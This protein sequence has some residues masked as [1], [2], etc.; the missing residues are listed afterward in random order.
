MNLEEVKALATGII[1]NGY[2][3]EMSEDDIKMEMF[4]QKV[5]Y[6]KLNTLFKTISISLGLMV[7]P[8]EVTDGIN[9]LVEKIDWESKTEWSQVAETL[10]H[11]V[12]NVDGSTVARALT[13]VR[14]HCRDEEIEL[15]KKPRASG[16]GGGAKGGKVAAAIADI[17]AKGVPTKEELYNAVLPLVKGPKNA[18]AFVNMYFGICVAVKT[19]ESL[20]TA[21][22]STKDQKMP[23][24]ETAEVESDEDED[25]MDD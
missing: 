16:G 5:P 1:E 20:A 24:Y 23:E 11:I 14:A 7:D 9:A 2:A 8:K 13:L 15:P 18:E 19:G 17:F 4:T 6:S 25:E 21:M 12:D 22:A 3:E 10:D